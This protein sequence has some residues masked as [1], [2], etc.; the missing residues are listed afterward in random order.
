MTIDF[1]NTRAYNISRRAMRKKK[2]ALILIAV[3]ALCGTGAF[4]AACGVK[5]TAQGQWDLLRC[6]DGEGNVLAYGVNVGGNTDVEKMNVTCEVSS[7]RFVARYSGNT[8]Y[9]EYEER[10]ESDNVY[11]TVTMDNGI[12]MQA[13]C[14]LYKSANSEVQ[15]MDITYDGKVY[16]FRKI[17]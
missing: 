12:T 17:A 4:V 9:G 15:L 13:V 1:R 7:S 5:A 8:Y 11:L 14:Y 2:V 16:T 6:T 3:L 10:E